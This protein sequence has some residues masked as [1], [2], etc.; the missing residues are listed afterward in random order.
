MKLKKNISLKKGKKNIQTI[1]NK[2]IEIKSKKN[3]FKGWFGIMRC[4][5][6]N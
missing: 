1:S 2:K 4:H 6:P 5:A 3:K